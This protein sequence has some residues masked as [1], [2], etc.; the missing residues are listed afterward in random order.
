MRHRLGLFENSDLIEVS[1]AVFFLLLRRCQHKGAPMKFVFLLGLLSFGLQ[2]Q[3]KTLHYYQTQVQAKNREGKL[4][5]ALSVL[6]GWT[7]QSVMKTKVVET[8]PDHNG[9]PKEITWDQDY[10]LKTM[11]EAFGNAKINKAMIVN[12]GHE[13]PKIQARLEETCT[14]QFKRRVEDDPRTKEDESGYVTDT[15]TLNMSWDCQIGG[16]SMPKEIGE[17]QT[18]SCHEGRYDY[19][20]GDGFTDVFARLRDKRIDVTMQLEKVQESSLDYFH[21][22]DGK[23]D[24]DAVILNLSQGVKGHIGEDDFVFNV[25]IDGGQKLKISRDSG[26]L[27][28]DIKYCPPDKRGNISV[29]VDAIEEDFP[30]SLSD[31]YRSQEIN[32]SAKGGKGTISLDRKNI[33]GT[34]KYQSS[35]AVEVKP[36]Q[37]AAATPAYQAK[38]QTGGASADW[39]R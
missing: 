11:S 1:P 35:I 32:V 7:C 18:Y 28:D 9:K 4:V 19:T 10:D 12:H 31:Q 6:S 20:N 17:K 14:Q 30:K 16:G 8:Q 34:P 29:K 13:E 3:A 5:S 25:A 37:P 23:P 15:R 33:F 22:C 36:Y 38:S 27:S 39:A 21:S 26:L 24:S 2:V